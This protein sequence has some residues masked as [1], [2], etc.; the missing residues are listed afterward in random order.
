[1]KWK[2]LFD[3]LN[4]FI[5]ASSLEPIAW[6][7]SSYRIPTQNLVAVQPCSEVALLDMHASPP[8]HFS[9]ECRLIFT[10]R[11]Y[12]G[13]SSDPDQTFKKITGRVLI[14]IKIGSGSDMIIIC[15]KGNSYQNWVTLIYSDI[16]V[17]GFFKTCFFQDVLST[18]SSK[19]TSEKP[20]GSLRSSARKSSLKPSTAT[21]RPS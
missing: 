9:T 19:T 6:A 3:Y 12:L 11:T 16:S 14:Q 17:S 8:P 18:S 4:V 2:R 10:R 5:L 20:A 15:Q 13:Q 7:I 21:P 1:M